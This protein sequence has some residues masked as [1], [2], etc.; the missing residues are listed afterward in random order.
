MAKCTFTT[1][2]GLQHQN[3]IARVFN[4]RAV[5]LAIQNTHMLRLHYLHGDVTNFL[6]WQGS[7][8]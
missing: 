4:N 6:H 8:L 1:G 3:N 2:V 5:S 7:L